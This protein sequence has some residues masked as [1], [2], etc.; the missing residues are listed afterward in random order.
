[1]QFLI[2]GVCLLVGLL[3]AGRWFMIADPKAV[4]RVVRW[5]GI[6]LGVV[7]VLFLATRIGIAGLFPLVIAALLFMARRRRMF[8]AAGRSL[9]RGA[10]PTPGQTSDVETAMLRMTLDHD[11]GEVAGSVRRG[12]FEGRDLQDLSFRELLDLYVECQSE[13]EQ[14]M[15]LLETFLDRVHG[16]DWRERADAEFGGAAGDGSGKSAMTTD[17]AYEVLG[18]DTGASEDDVKEAHHRLMMKMHPD[19]GGSTYLASKINQAKDL[20]LGNA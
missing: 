15:N 20:L 2:L 12:R 13:D 16:A 19:Q 7:F 3:L 9:G 8:G 6:I 17:E 10:S 14:S 1:M 5:A 18:L 4:A 11:S